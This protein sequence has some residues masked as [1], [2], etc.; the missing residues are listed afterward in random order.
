VVTLRIVAL[1]SL[2][3]LAGC[4]TAERNAA[5]DAENMERLSAAKAETGDE[6][7]SLNES[8]EEYGKMTLLDDET[9]EEKIVCKYIKQTG[10]RFGKKVCATPFEWEQKRKE[11]RRQVEGIQRNMNAKCPGGGVC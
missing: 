9:G 11:S 3:V 4:A 10:T 8:L 5:R 6:K 7:V 2:M 1:S